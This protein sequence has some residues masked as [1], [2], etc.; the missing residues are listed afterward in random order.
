MLWQ[1]SSQLG[2]LEIGSPFTYYIKLSNHEIGCAF[3]YFIKLG[4]HEIGCV[5]QTSSN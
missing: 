5:L 4:Y 1:T 2:N 3:T